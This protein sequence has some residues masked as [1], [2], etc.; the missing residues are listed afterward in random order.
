M[1]GKP[2][3][4]QGDMTAIGGPIVQG[5]LG[6]MIGAPT[7]VACSVC[8]GGHTSG[9]PVNPLLGAKVQPG[10]TDFTL[11]GPLPFILSRTYSSYQTKTPSPVGAFG[12]GW[13]TPGDIRLQLRARELI[14]NDNGGRSIHFDL[15][16]PGEIAFS[17]S[18]SFWLARGGSLKLHESHPLH[19]LWQSL[20]EQNRLS[21]NTYFATNSPQGPWWI[22]GWAEHVPQEGESLPLPLSDYRIL[23]GLA[24]NLGR[25]L[26]FHRAADTG[27]ITG[28]TDGAGRHFDM[29]YLQFADVPQTHYGP[30]NGRRLTEVWLTRDPEYPGELPAV[31]LVRYQY[32][33][34]GEL[35][36][37]YDRSGSQTRHFTYDEKFPGR[38]VAHHHA[39]RPEI[40][41]RYDAAGRVTDQR[42]PAG[43]SYVYAYEKN[44]IVITDSLN[45]REEL[46]TAGEGG[47]KR[48]VKKV[49]ADG[50]VSC[51]DFDA[52]GRQKAQTDAA[53]RKTVFRINAA[54]GLV[55]AR[56]TTDGRVT[57]FYYNSQRQLSC[58]IWPDGLR[59]RHEYDESGRLTRE[60]L[61]TG[62]TTTYTFADPHSVYPTTREDASGSQQQMVWNRYGQLLT[63]TD[64][65]GYETRYQY[66]RFGQ[67]IAY[68]REEGLSQYF[69]YD[70]HGRLLSQ[71]DPT[72]HQTHYE[73]TAAGDLTAVIAPDGTRR[74]TE[75]DRAGRPVIA[76]S[77]SLTRQMEYD[78]AGRMTQLTNENGSHMKF[79]YD[80]LDRLTLE[81]GFDERTRHYGYD[82]TG[83]LTQSEDEGLIT[84]WY[85]DDIDRL[86]HRTVNNVA[87]EQWQY[88]ER[89]W[90]TG[91]SHLSEGHRVAIQYMNDDKGRRTGERQT[92][93]HP[94][95]NEL[96]WQHETL[97][98]WN[99]QGQQHRFTP[100]NLAPVEWLT[101][102][103]GHLA[104]MKL[105][106]VPLIDFTR[107]RLHREIQRTFGAYELAT[108]FTPGGQLKSHHL[109]TPLLNRDYGWD[110]NGHLTLINGPYQQREYRYSSAG[111]LTGVHITSAALN[112]TIPFSFDPAGNRLI[113]QEWHPDTS[114]T[115]WPNNRIAQ[116]THY[117]YQ[118]DK[119]GNLTRQEINLPPGAVHLSGELIRHYRYDHQHRLVA[120]TCEQIWS[121][122]VV[123]ESRYL[124]DPLG[125]RIGKKVWKSHRYGT[126][127]SELVVQNPTP[128]VTWYGWDGDRLTT[129]QTETQ[130]VQTVYLPGSFT[131]VLRIETENAELAKTARRSLADKLQQD[132]NIAFPAE[133]ISRL[134]MLERELQQNAV[135]EEN[136]Q[137]LAGCGLTVEQMAKQMEPFYEPD[138]KIHLYHCDHRGLPLALFN[139]NG[140]IAWCGEYDEWGNQL[141][142]DNP[143]NLQQL[144]R[145]PGQQYDEETG[146]HYNR[147]R[148]YDPRQGR[149]ITQDPIGLRGGWNSYGYPLNPISK[150]DAL[151]LSGFDSLGNWLGQS[152]MKSAYNQSIFESL[153]AIPEP[154]SEWSFVGWSVDKGARFGNK[155]ANVNAIC[156][157]QFGKNKL[158]NA[159][160]F[161][162]GWFLI[163]E[164]EAGRGIP[165]PGEN[166]S[167]AASATDTITDNTKDL[168]DAHS[169]ALTC[170]SKSGYQCFMDNE[171]TKELGRKLCG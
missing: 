147:H 79:A 64:C 90:L 75:F 44:L 149:Y 50:S 58:T 81:S 23:S 82:V 111:R 13:K 157:D 29:Q 103:S 1:S 119:H 43:L 69:Q 140:A 155:Y 12:P 115:G 101:Y 98:D 124:Y 18:E 88:N 164:V 2:A 73:Y 106:D 48:V 33:T 100:D 110:A 62:H 53:G 20:S 97:Y 102:G 9:N 4:R 131:P 144:I 19:R 143:E 108:G 22:L 109:N 45:R 104:G 57:E 129:T 25:G 84:R 17:H 114:L 94:E 28:V 167:D 87:A 171:A 49:F 159:K 118:H 52:Y 92:V 8:P 66:D 36:A 32:S 120:H 30:D 11:P 168:Y 78:A 113:S 80:S 85:Y 74:T 55:N 21:Q 145:L 46:H 135:S 5:S 63:F 14:L 16:L 116:D 165:D 59:S 31:P 15:L 112:I 3:A 39:G 148:Y 83:K 96:L 77:D 72:G 121:H 65:S 125:R 141:N 151:G 76:T 34:R 38:M 133:L 132:G 139:E 42:N 41:Y 142:E 123:A 71:T 91:I 6:V 152:G 156:K 107:D 7:G 89:G 146:L 70:S 130:R 37:V 163:N 60:T 51:S 56:V 54:S 105:G 122:R 153:N 137:W 154:V 47:L 127:Y 27:E 26:A 150:I 117:L 138:R 61:R 134:D 68:H 24:D 35:Q 10:E 169:M 162:S 93:H 67:L 99:V 160:T 158:V 86:T 40:H 126:G 128:E 95:T 166:S 170:G 136:R 161:Q